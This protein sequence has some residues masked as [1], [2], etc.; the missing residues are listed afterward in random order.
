[1]EEK[2]DSDLSSLMQGTPLGRNE[3]W[4]ARPLPALPLPLEDCNRLLH[5]PVQH[6][7]PQQEMKKW[8][9]W[10]ETKLTMSIAQ[11]EGVYGVSAESEPLPRV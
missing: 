1:M 8:T 11:T 2:V 9:I 3:P 4:T 5:L 7:V 6:Q 10:G